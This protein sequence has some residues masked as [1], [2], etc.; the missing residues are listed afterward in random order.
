MNRI[1]ALLVLIPFGIIA[2]AC[3][4]QSDS[5]DDAAGG[6]DLQKN[7]ITG[8]AAAKLVIDTG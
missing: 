4:S 3:S 5:G 8:I 1:A 6:E 2:A 7:P